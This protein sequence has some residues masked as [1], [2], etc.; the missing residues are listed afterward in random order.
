M[1]AALLL[2]VLAQGLGKELS[3]D[4]AYT[5]LC[6]ALPGPG[7]SLS[8]LTVPNNHMLYSVLLGLL[9]PF[10]SEPLYRLLSVLF[11]VGSV[12]L[13]GR[14][15]ASMIPKTPPAVCWVTILAAYLAFPPFLTLATQVRGY[16]LSMLLVAVLLAL[17]LPV[18]RPSWGAVGAY[19][20]VGALALGT[21]ITNALPLVALALFDLARLG[22]RRELS[23][24]E[25]LPRATRHLLVVVGFCFYVPVWR[26]LAA[27]AVYGWGWQPKDLMLA[28]V[29]P[30]VLPFGLVAVALLVRG[31]AARRK[32]RVAAIEEPGVLLALSTA[33]V[34]GA[35]LLAGVGL[36]PRSFISFLPLVITAFSAFAISRLQDRPALLRGLT[37]ATAIVGQVYWQASVNWLLTDGRM[38]LP[39]LF[40]PPQFEARDFDPYEAMRAS[41]A[42]T[43]PPHNCLVV[44]DNRD[45]LSEEMAFWYYAVL[46]GVEKHILLA[47]RGLHPT[48]VLARGECILVVSRDLAGRDGV[49]EALGIGRVD[50]MS[51]KNQ[52]F[53]KVWRVAFRRSSS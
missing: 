14:S 39:Q 12:W 34:I 18:H 20:T 30:L 47:P 19:G 29:F 16:S 40:L 41:A 17:V 52:G 37:L 27:N 15:L 11:A 42:W 4:E 50:F 44:V 8:H 46:E 25:V 24:H 45:H 32:T 28:L 5:V 2:A 48:A 36:F 31:L 1:F 38:R 13:T 21:L 3:Y 35:V 7:F 26:D 51:V 22:L 6:Y 49:A 53:F 9:T 23:W 33:A 10:R 43:L